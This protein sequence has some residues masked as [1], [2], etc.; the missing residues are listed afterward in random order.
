[1][2][3]LGSLAQ[4]C[5]WTY[6]RNI[7]QCIET[8]PQNISLKTCG[9]YD[10]QQVYSIMIFV[11]NAPRIIVSRMWIT[12]ECSFRLATNLF[13]HFYNFLSS[14]PQACVQNQIKYISSSWRI[15]IFLYDKQMNIWRMAYQINDSISDTFTMLNN[16][17]SINAYHKN[18]GI[19]IWCLKHSLILITNS[20][21]DLS[22]YFIWPQKRPS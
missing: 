2:V 5:I 17:F 6:H 4:S 12:N 3:F 19:K 20:K 21:V 9:G 1:M 18:V 22:T 16:V 8:I 10:F 15:C 14:I 7:V 13:F 11:I